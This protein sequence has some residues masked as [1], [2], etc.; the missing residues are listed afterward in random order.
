MKLFRGFRNRNIVT[1][2]DLFPRKWLVYQKHSKVEQN[3]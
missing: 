1:K 2:A 3:Y